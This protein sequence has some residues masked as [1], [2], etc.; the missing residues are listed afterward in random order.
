MENQLPLQVR[1]EEIGKRL[2]LLYP[3][4]AKSLCALRFGNEF[5]LLAATILS[6]QCTDERVNTVT[7]V[8]FS[9]YH[10]PAELGAADIEDV[11]QII[12]STGF[13]REKAKNLIKMS[14]VVAKRYQGTVPNKMEEL[15]SLP[16]VGRKTA[17]V[18]LSVGFM[19]PGLPVDTHVKRLSKR[20]GLSASDD[21]VRIE[22]ELNKLISE[23]ERGSFSLRLIL[24]GRKVCQARKP[25]CEACELADICPS[26]L[27]Q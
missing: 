24:H 16:G 14:S 1:S 9:K 15:V 27:P 13:Y 25:R 7:E 17:N 3:G 8:L 18:V 11:E 21:P 23:D 10:T 12:R 20:L 4:T 22:Q 19:L 26:S 6:A 2:A 5:E